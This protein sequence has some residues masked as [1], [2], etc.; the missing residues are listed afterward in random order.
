MTH[1]TRRLY[2]SSVLATVAIDDSRGWISSGQGPVL[3][4]PGVLAG[5]AIGYALVNAFE[6]GRTGTPIRPAS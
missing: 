5:V 2:G 3:A 6:A 4:T 1:Q